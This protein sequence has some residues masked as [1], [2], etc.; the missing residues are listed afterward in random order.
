MLSAEWADG[1]GDAGGWLLQE[2][3]KGTWVQEL[4]QTSPSL[5]A[6]RSVASLRQLRGNVGLGGLK[7]S[8][9]G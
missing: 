7:Q 1:E 5:N 3:P 4:G 9:L 8:P 6:K 2:Q